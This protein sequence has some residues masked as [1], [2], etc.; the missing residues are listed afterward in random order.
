MNNLSGIGEGFGQ[1]SQIWG[2]LVDSDP[3]LASRIPGGATAPV[4]VHEQL[5]VRF[6]VWLAVGALVVAILMR[7]NV[8]K[9]PFD[10]DVDPDDVVKLYESGMSSNEI[11]KKFGVTSKAVLDLLRKQKVKIREK[12]HQKKSLKTNKNPIPKDMTDEEVEKIKELYLGGH[13]MTEIEKITGIPRYKINNLLGYLGIKK[14]LPSKPRLESPFEPEVVAYYLSGNTVQETADNFNVSIQSIYSILKREGIELEKRG[15]GRKGGDWPVDEIVKLYNDGLTLR[16]IA[17]EYDTNRQTISNI[18]ERAGVEKRPKRMG[19]MVNLDKKKISKEYLKGSSLQEL[20]E[21]YGASITSIANALKE[22]GTERR[23]GRR[24]L[25]T[26]AE[27]RK[28]ADKYL[29]GKDLRE[30]ALDYLVDPETI[31]NVLKELNIRRRPVGK[32]KKK[33]PSITLEEF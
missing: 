24:E 16:Q 10:K 7:S 11:A 20:S 25:F 2:D 5:P 33:N 17:E 21:K 22:L 23:S 3:T 28:I 14:S 6:F 8:K 4:V 1:G 26:K 19:V 27:K 29:K 9:N 32:R 30:I 31:R 13:K 18:L 12:G 15:S